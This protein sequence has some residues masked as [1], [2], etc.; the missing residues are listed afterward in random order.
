MPTYRSSRT[1]DSMCI[2]NSFTTL[3]GWIRAFLNAKKTNLDI[4]LSGGY[5]EPLCLEP[6]LAGDYVKHSDNAGHRETDDETAACFS[7]F[8]YILSQKML[9]VCDI[10]GVGTF[11][12]DPQIH[13]ID[14]EG[15]GAGNLGAEG[16]RRFLRT[17]RH[18]LLC[19]ELGGQ[20]W[21]VELVLAKLLHVQ[22]P[23]YDSIG[24]VSFLHESYLMFLRNFLPQAS[25]LLPFSW[26]MSQIENEQ[27]KSD[28]IRWNQMTRIKTWIN[29]LP[30]QRL[31]FIALEAFP[32]LMKACRMKSWHRRSR[33]PD[34]N[35]VNE[36]N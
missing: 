26:T 34:V 25:K 22:R 13:T 28:E 2:Y 1:E 7:Y 6:Y 18:N 23:Y 3:L 8:S 32:A 19:E 21:T 27:M 20:S 33:W 36:V 10:Q 35:D 31:H 14:G 16:I 11:Y 12:T 4:E 30:D 15:F 29:L 17:H 5:A 24:I 9:V